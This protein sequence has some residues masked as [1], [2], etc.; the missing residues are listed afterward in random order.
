LNEELNMNTTLSED[1]E[2]LLHAYVDGEVTEAERARVENER[3]A[4]PDIQK[5][6]EEIESLRVLA[7]EAFS[8]AS[9]EVDLGG[10]YDGIMSRIA[11]EDPDAQTQDPTTRSLIEGVIA[12]FK[13]MFSVERPLIGFGAAACMVAAIALFVWSPGQETTSPPSSPSVANHSPVPSK[14]ARRGMELEGRLTGSV[15]KLQI[16]E[17]ITRVE[18][19]DDPDTPMVVWHEIE[20]ETEDNAVN[21]QPDASNE[22]R[23]L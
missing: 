21:A 17:G 10:V 11:D 13:A 23:G 22:S 6:I 16:A 14:G 20:G 2:A 9:S 15:E 4:N 7:A 5:K 19:A 8:S 18:F 3:S 12:S 1:F